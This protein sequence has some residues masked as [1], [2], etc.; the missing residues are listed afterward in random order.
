MI[1]VLAGAKLVSMRYDLAL[2]SIGCPSMR[3]FLG[4]FLCR[5]V[6]VRRW[7]QTFIL[8]LS[9]L[10]SVGLR[11][12]NH[13][14]TWYRFFG[15]LMCQLFVK[16]HQFFRFL[17]W[18]SLVEA[19]EIHQM[20]VSEVD[21]FGWGGHLCAVNLLLLRQHLGFRRRPILY[22]LSSVWFAVGRL[23]SISDSNFHRPV[24]GGIGRDPSDFLA[25][26]D[27]LFFR[28][29][30][31]SLL[32]F[33]RRFLR[34]A[35]SLNAVFGCW[36]LFSFRTCLWYR[37]WLNRSITSGFCPHRLYESKGSDSL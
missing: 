33:I 8:W 32:R 3:W 31:G 23:V 15:T 9:G 18:I 29:W 25:E 21:L 2:M 14:L 30:G 4:L 28:V 11:Q 37:R 17:R 16:I 27:L 10:L 20:F 5:L 19:V 13:L 36:R 12:W 26:L 35:S 24:F 1:F 34:W 22:K 6:P 7:L